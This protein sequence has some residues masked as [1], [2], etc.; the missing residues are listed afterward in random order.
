MS[1]PHTTAHLPAPIHRQREEREEEEG[2]REGEREGVVEVEKG[3]VMEVRA[4]SHPKMRK[5][6]DEMRTGRLDLR[7]HSPVSQ[8]VC[9]PPSQ[10]SSF[11]STPALAVRQIAVCLSPPASL[12][13]PWRAV[14]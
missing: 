2:E 4:A 13:P 3:E 5:E 8:G 1:A 12:S 11:Q 14:P 7:T 9:P 6:E 10:T